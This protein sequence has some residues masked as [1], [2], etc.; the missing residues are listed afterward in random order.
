[1][2]ATIGA[3]SRSDLRSLSQRPDYQL[4]IFHACSTE[5]YLN[6]L[7]N[8]SVFNRDMR[9][10]DIIATTMAT[11]LGNYGDQS[12]GFLDGVLRRD[13][14]QTMT[15]ARSQ[16]EVD[17][18]NRIGMTELVNDARMTYSTSGFLGNPGNR[19]RARTP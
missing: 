14:T 17:Y 2:R 12:L 1:L 6:N 8:P 19:T 16:S 18:L 13:S 15:A 5:E 7:R 11:R 4:L 10:T 3:D 9:N